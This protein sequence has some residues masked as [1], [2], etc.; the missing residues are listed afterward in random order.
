MEET[1]GTSDLLVHL[2]SLCLF[3]FVGNVIGPRPIAILLHKD[4]VR[5][6]SVIASLLL[7]SLAFVCREDLKG[8]VVGEFH[9]SLYT[10]LYI[11]A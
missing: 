1:L 3:V 9:I 6:E 4:G 7:L 11:Y 8:L 10:N 5:L 2:V